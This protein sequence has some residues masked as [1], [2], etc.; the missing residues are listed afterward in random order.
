MLELLGYILLFVAGVTLSWPCIRA[1]RLSQL[2]EQ[3]RRKMEWGTYEAQAL[4]HQVSEFAG[5]PVNQAELATYGALTAAELVWSWARIDPSVITAADFS[6][7]VPIHNGFDFAQY[8]H[9]HY[10]T[11]GVAAKEGFFDR[12]MGYV[13]EQQVADLLVHQGHI[14][15]MA[16]SSAQPLWD[17]LVDG[18][19][20]N[21]KTVQ[22]LAS[23]K[24][25][26]MAHHGMTYIVPSD[27]HGQ[28]T[29]NMT[30][31][32]GFHHEA[33]HSSLHEGIAAAHGE[34][35]M[36]SLGMHLPLL[37]IGFAAYRN[38]QS[39]QLGKEVALAMKHTVVESVGRGGGG[40][41]GAAIGHAAAG[42]LFG[43]VGLLVG[44]IVGAV[45]GGLL[46]GAV[47]EQ[48]KRK[49]LVAATIHMET[50][51]HEYGLTFAGKLDTVR[52]YLEAPS[53]RMRA[54]LLE[55]ERDLAARKLRLVWWLWP[56]FY[57]VLLEETA[58]QGQKEIVGEQQRVSRVVDIFG[59]ASRT[60]R[61]EKIG[62]MMVNLPAIS[63]LVGDSPDKRASVQTA[64]Q[65][66]FHERKQLNPR[67]TA[68]V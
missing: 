68:P 50:A 40:I 19:P 32:A 66:V 45:G 38:Y 8:L 22:Q 59:E 1:V 27:A 44:G 35:A 55:I 62:L 36:H 61:L 51:L 60:G 64:R 15:Q 65:A 24:A 17:M 34:H 2:R 10:D 28:L 23:I 11:L 25:E 30:H 29:A 52:G 49:P 33:V 47:A 63:E 48:I 9:A 37:T 20:I 31:V 67:F 39:V 58:L 53:I 46:G 43:P 54:S 4:R 57:T 6:S 13:G 14:V 16:A 42:A 26:A 18:H 41:V 56:D 3:A 7:S 12:L 5:Q 21:V